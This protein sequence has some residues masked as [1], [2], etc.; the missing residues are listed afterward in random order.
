MQQKKRMYTFG[1]LKCLL[2]ILYF[3]FGYQEMVYAS[4]NLDTSIIDSEEFMDIDQAIEDLQMDTQ[5]NFRE[6]VLDLINGDTKLSFETIKDFLLAELFGQAA[7]LKKT[8]IPMLIIAVAA[9][10][11]NNFS[12]LFENHQ[13]SDISY[14]VIYMIMLAILV[15]S[16]VNAAVIAKNVMDNLLTFMKALIPAYFLTVAL[17]SGTTTALVFYQ[18][19]LAL[20]TGVNWVFLNILIPMIHIYVILVLV[21]NLSK[22]DYLSRLAELLKKGIEW[23]LKA[24]LA[25]VVGFNVIQGLMAQA[26]DSFKTTMF[27]KTV[28]MIPGVGNAANAVT[29]MVIGSA[30]VIKNGVGVAALIFIVM[31]C[32][33]PMIQLWIFMATYQLAAAVIQPISDK[34]MIGC[35]SCIGEG[36]RLFLRVITT[37]AILFFITIAIVT[38]SSISY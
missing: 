4:E 20:I 9:A 37:S 33:V 12:N 23:L 26:L 31:V 14:Y 5:I 29:D 17:S 11:L 2:T 22:E 21:N 16:F 10:M 36:S 15:N 28:S 27:S 7:S 24:T 13:I 30:V 3:T 1:G 38:A 19:I 6:L 25:L 34:R 35:I 32:A 18:F 8:L